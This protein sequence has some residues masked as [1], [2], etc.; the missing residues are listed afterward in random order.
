M[1]DRVDSHLQDAGAPFIGLAL[2]VITLGEQSFLVAIVDFGMEIGVSRCV[3]TSDDD[4]II[5]AIR[6]NRRH[7]SRFVLTRTPI[8]STTLAVILRRTAEERPGT[9]TLVTSFIGQPA[10]R[11]WY[12]PRATDEDRAF[13][14]SNALVWDA[15]TT[16]PESMC[17]DLPA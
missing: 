7:Y 5:Y 4:Q 11:E 12:D 15:T 14:R 10:A 17:S 1:Y 16:I 8:P 6:R 13:W 9:A 2:D 3:P